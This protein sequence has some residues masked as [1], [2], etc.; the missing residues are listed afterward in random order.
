MTRVYNNIRNDIGRTFGQLTILSESAK[1][2][3]PMR[4]VLCRCSCGTEKILAYQNVLSGATK[5]C[6][7]Y[8][9]THI[10]N[11]FIHGRIKTPE[12]YS[13]SGMLA[14]CRNPKSEMYPIYGG[15][16]I[17]VCERWLKFVN[18]YEDMGDR[19]TPGHSLDRKNTNGNYCKDNCRWATS[20]EQAQNTRKTVL[21]TFNSR[22]MCLSSWAREIGISQGTLSA[23]LKKMTPCEA[24]SMP[25][26]SMSEAIRKSWIKRREKNT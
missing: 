16:G 20:S 3:S 11:S 15:R 25:V 12:Y 10:A 14:R 8:R 21:I 19:P 23:R 22:T 1:S 9:K 2:T 7:C 26:S 18:F 4:L 24:L 6:G 5:S 13:W 17:S